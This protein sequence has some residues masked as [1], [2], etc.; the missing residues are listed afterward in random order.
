MAWSANDSTVCPTSDSVV[1]YGSITPP[2]Y[3]KMETY[4]FREE[5]RSMPYRAGGPCLTRALGAGATSSL[6]RCAR[7]KRPW[8]RLALIFPRSFKRPEGRPSSRRMTRHCRHAHPR[9]QRRCRSWGRSDWDHRQV[10]PTSFFNFV[11]VLQFSLLSLRQAFAEQ[12][13][14]GLNIVVKG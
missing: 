1:S 5:T 4:T 2:M 11:I 7:K 14:S 10:R 9:R 6:E 3:P 13:G 12:I 8:S